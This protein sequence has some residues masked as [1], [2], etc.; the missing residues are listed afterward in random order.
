M[1]KTVQGTMPMYRASA[2]TLNDNDPASPGLDVN[3]NLL[4]SFGSLLAGEDL[5]NNVLKTEQRFTPLL[6]TADTQ[7]KA[8]AGFLHTITVSPND[9]A[10]TAGS[11]IVYDSLTEA[12]TQL[13]NVT[14][15]TT[16]FAPFTVTIDGIFST[17]LY[18]GFTTTADVN[19][20]V[21]Y[22]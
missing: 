13:F 14:V 8:G 22:R 10:P 12:S 15:T 3:G 11:I 5:V 7:V 18:V 21:S 2:I 4:T 6:V 9:A 17:G 19:V 20:T 1:S 16:W